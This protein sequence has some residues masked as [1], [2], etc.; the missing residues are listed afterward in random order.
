MSLIHFFRKLKLQ[1]KVKVDGSHKIIFLARQES[2]HEKIVIFGIGIDVFNQAKKK[3]IYCD[4][5]FLT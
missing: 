5:K 3:F 1:K 2:S 4:S